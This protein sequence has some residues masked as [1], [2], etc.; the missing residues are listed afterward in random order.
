MKTNIK[1][2]G[3]AA[4]FV[5]LS[6]VSATAV[7]ANDEGKTTSTIELRFIGNLENQP[8]FLLN[9]ANAEQEEFTITFRDEYGNVLYS[10]RVKGANISKKF[11]LNTDEIG[12]DILSVDVKAKKSG[13]VETFKINRSIVYVNETVVKK[14]Q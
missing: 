11:M 2:Y 7:K 14:V 8:V 5:A 12:N 3:I 1:N 6:L 13:K 4:L 9:L 10:D